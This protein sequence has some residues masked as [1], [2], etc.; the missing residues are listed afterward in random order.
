MLRIKVSSKILE[1]CGWIKLAI[2]PGKKSPGKI[3]LLKPG[4]NL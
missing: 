1:A 3:R 4:W 2:K